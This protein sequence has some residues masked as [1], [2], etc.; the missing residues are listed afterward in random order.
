MIDRKIFN[1]KKKYLK[2]KGFSFFII[3]I[4]F[5]VRGNIFININEQKTQ[6]RDKN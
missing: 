4:F 1:L 6:T 2:F 5:G 3:N